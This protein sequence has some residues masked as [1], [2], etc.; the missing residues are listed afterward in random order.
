M[1]MDHI[2]AVE[3][4][5]AAFTDAVTRPGA[6]AR[7]VS[8]CPGWTVRDLVTHLGEVQSFW[9]LVLRAGG[10]LPGEDEARAAK[11]YGDDLLGWWRERSAGLVR[12]LREVPADSPSWC[13]WNDE[14]RTTAGDVAYRQAHEALVHRWDAQH[15]VDVVRPTDPALASDGVDEFATR[16]LRG[17][18]WTGPSGVL[19][20]R[21]TDTGHERRFGCGAGSPSEDGCPRWLV[22]KRARPLAAVVTG[23]AEQ[24]DLMLWR[25]VQPEA[26]QVEG[27]AELLAAFLAWPGLD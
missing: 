27:D 6:L 21:A 19:A 17:G 5:S 4:Q 13:W 25:R 2:A 12:Q 22:D 24:L 16:F 3:E 9:T 23:S 7:T 8:A 20:L 1:R 14:N 10:E 18:D 26:D 15:A 11:D